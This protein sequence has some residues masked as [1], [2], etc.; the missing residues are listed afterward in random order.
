[1]D[2]EVD[3][4]DEEMSR[5]RFRVE[6]RPKAAVT[7]RMDMSWNIFEIIFAGFAC[8]AFTLLI[9]AYFD[10]YCAVEYNRLLC[11]NNPNRP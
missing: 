3:L 1:M 10:Y 6:L 8:I 7:Y 2:K 5:N 4:C 11:N 9:N